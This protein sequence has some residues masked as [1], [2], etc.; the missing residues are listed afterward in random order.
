MKSEAVIVGAGLSGLRIASLLIR[1][2]IS[3]RV[4]EAR[5]RLGGRILTQEVEGKPEYGRFDLGPTWFWPQYERKITALIGELGLE[6]FLQYNRGR[7]VAERSRQEPPKELELAEGAMGDVSARIAGGAAALI[8]AM[9]RTLPEGI[10]ELKRRVTSVRQGQAGNVWV[11]IDGD[12]ESIA[13]KVV[14]M[15]LPPRLI[16]RHI[17]FVPELPPELTRDL[18]S[19]PTWMAA[20]AKA[21]AVYERPF[22]RE[23]GR[24]GFATSWVG[25]L[26]EIHDAS[27][28]NGAG[29]LFGFFGL[30]AQTRAALGTDHI[31]TLVG[32]QLARL[33]GPPAADPVA[34]LYKD[35]AVDAD[36]AIAEDAAP[37]RLHPHYAP[38]A[39]DYLGW[40]SVVYF[41]GTETARV[42][43]GHLEGALQSADRI[44]S[45]V[46]AALRAQ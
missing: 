1:Q 40:N 4:L 46:I 31:R 11:D 34:M 17:A 3:C 22:W 25:P 20:Q 35:W 9:V 5:D 33:F 15:A 39:A 24:S 43:G 38:P 41:A 45:Q 18:F 28:E 29:A 21:V 19:K 16:T 8:Q 44:A 36:T 27:P 7:M 30:D 26:Q 42:Q 23:Q 6:T 32:E 37:I 10:V 12:K 14:I 2:G 13:A